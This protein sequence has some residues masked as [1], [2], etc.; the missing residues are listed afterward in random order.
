MFRLI[1]ESLQLGEVQQEFKLNDQFYRSVLWRYDRLALL[2]ATH[3]T[4]VKE[5]L[6]R[7]MEEQ[8]M[9]ARA[10]GCGVVWALASNLYEWQLCRYDLAGE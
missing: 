10:S 8:R 9:Y 6:L 3:K 4:S 5:A 2:V 7:V 1:I